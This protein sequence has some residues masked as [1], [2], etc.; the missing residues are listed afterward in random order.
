VT[1]FREHGLSISLDDFGTGFAS[2][3]H[4]RDFPFDELKIDRSF[5]ANIGTDIRSEQI[6][7]AMVD[8]SRNLGKRC[9]AEGIETDIQRRFLLSAGCE[10]GQGYLFAKPQ[11]A[12]RAGAHLPKRFTGS[13]KSVAA[14]PDI[15][16]TTGWLT[17]SQPLNPS[18][19]VG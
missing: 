7:R 19:T 9:V 5:V 14:R 18:E 8:L 15:G 6:I 13:K 2:L 17:G 11:P 1:R 12:A 3:V 10:I 16:R 4:L